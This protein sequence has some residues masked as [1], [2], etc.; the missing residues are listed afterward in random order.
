MKEY[1]VTYSACSMYNRDD[2]WSFHQAENS[3]QAIEMAIKDRKEMSIDA[4]GEDDMDVSKMEIVDRAFKNGFAIYYD[5][6]LQDWFT[7]FKA[8][9]LIN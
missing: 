7:D 9:E 3:E 2:E 8:E 1:K 4:Y 5:D 6:E